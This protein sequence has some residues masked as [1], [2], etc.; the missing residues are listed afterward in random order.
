MA[1]S[2]IIR[3]RG[4]GLLGI[5]FMRRVGAGPAVLVSTSVLLERG[6]CET[7]ESVRHGD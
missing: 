6:G 2:D 7:L 3:V 4:L 5:Q 1:N